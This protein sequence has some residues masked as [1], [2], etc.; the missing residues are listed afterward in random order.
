MMKKWIRRVVI[1]VFAVLFVFTA[2]SM[3]WVSR[4]YKKLQLSPLVCNLS[5][6]GVSPEEFCET[7]GGETPLKGK[8]Y[9]T[10]RVDKDGNLLLRVHEDTIREWKSG[11][12]TMQV[13]QRVLGETR[14]IGVELKA[15]DTFSKDR[16]PYIEGAATCGFEISEDFTQVIQSSDDDPMYSNILISACLQMQ[17]FEGK[18][19]SATKVEYIVLD[20]DGNETEKTV[21]PAEMEDGKLDLLIRWD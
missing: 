11:L 12:F 2:F 7:D 3:W 14:D 5:L 9:Y 19:S 8:F 15:L 18:E 20:V 16:L 6:N 17:M 21:F 13:L 1:V 10:S 4:Y